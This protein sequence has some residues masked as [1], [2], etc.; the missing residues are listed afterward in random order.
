MTQLEREQAARVLEKKV[1]RAMLT[2][3]VYEE[4]I[5]ALDAAIACLR[6]P[7]TSPET[8][9]KAGGWVRTSDEKP[10]SG[11]VAAI[12]KVTAGLDN[13]DALSCPVITDAELVREEPDALV[14]W[15]QLPPL[16]E[17]EG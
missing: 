11:L 13:H 5:D 1:K 3:S 9:G 12:E 6:S 10:K 14:Y 4:W 8:D 16:P 15:Y 17:V 2:D 7:I